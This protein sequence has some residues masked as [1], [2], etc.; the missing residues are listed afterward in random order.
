MKE[1]GKMI[2]A[3]VIIFL[4]FRALEWII[5]GPTQTILVCIEDA[6]GEHDCSEFKPSKE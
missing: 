1:T 2:I 3:L 6:A 4:V 5:P